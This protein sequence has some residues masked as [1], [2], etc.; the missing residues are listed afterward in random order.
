MKQ[1]KPN[2][3]IIVLDILDKYNI[4]FKDFFKNPETEGL[5]DKTKSIEEKNKIIEALPYRKTLKVLSDI[6]KG[7]IKLEDL[8]KEIQI[9]LKLAPDLAEEISKE[10]KENIF[11]SDSSSNNSKTQPIDSY[12]EEV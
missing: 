8:S 2:F 12:R 11:E 9:K 5:L 7:T 6:K 4:Y 10:I 1:F 3:E